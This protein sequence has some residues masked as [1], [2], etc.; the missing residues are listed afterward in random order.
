VS[1]DIDNTTPD[2]TYSSDWVFNAH[3]GDLDS[4]NGIEINGEYAYLITD[5]YPYVSRCLNGEATASG[6][7]GE[8][9]TAVLPAPPQ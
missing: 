5:T 1:V 6:P 3:A 7:G 2:G 8:E 4:C 9:L